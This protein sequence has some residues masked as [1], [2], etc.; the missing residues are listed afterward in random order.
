MVAGEPAGPKTARWGDG[1]SNGLV[2]VFRRAVLP[3]L[4]SLFGREGAEDVAMPDAG[5]GVTTAEGCGDG[6]S[7]GLVLDFRRVLLLLLFRWGRLEDVAVPEATLDATTA[8]GCGDGVS[9]GLV[10]R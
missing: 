9:N 5:L 1:V 4:L 10:L 8:G 2:L 7:N 3:L 6:V